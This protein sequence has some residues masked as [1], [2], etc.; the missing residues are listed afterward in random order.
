MATQTGIVLNMPNATAILVQFVEHAQ[1]QGVFLLPEAD[2]LKRCKDLLLNGNQD[3]EISVIMARQLLVQAVN[4]GQTKGVYT[5]DEA[6]VLY[7]VCNFVSTHL[8]EESTPTPT[9]TQTPQLQ[10]LEEEDE[11]DD[12]LNTLSE[13]VPLKPRVV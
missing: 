6:A 1:K 2:I 11:D 4:K 5:L 13:D 8:N 10:T 12:D 9:P 3:N 7:K